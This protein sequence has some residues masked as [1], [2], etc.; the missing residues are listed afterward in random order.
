MKGFECSYQHDK[1][2]D[3]WECDKDILVMN[4]DDGG[5]P[6]DSA[7]DG[8]LVSSRKE[9]IHLPTDVVNGFDKPDLV[10]KVECMS[11]VSFVQSTAT[12]KLG[13]NTS[14]NFILQK[15]SPNQV[16][17]SP[18][19]EM[20]PP[21]VLDNKYVK[22]DLEPFLDQ[23]YYNPSILEVPSDMILLKTP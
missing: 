20:D 3:H 19:R 18:N 7:L 1:E 8:L 13:P 4:L 5:E 22:L 10:G 14:N 21:C 16:S 17:G 12:S 15:C 11:D 9:T 2:P 6:H 23:H